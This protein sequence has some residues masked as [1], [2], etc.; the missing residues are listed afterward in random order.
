MLP[1]S[2][3]YAYNFANSVED[4]KMTDWL[5]AS[6]QGSN[7]SGVLTETFKASEA[8]VEAALTVTR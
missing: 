5:L 7:S 8:L 6:V 1:L 2:F 3:F 4:G